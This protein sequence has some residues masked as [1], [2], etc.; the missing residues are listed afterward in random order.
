VAHFGAVMFHVLGMALQKEGNLLQKL[1]EQTVAAR[2]QVCDKLMYDHFFFFKIMIKIILIKKLLQGC[3][4]G[5]A[6]GG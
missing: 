6:A 2:A 5:N 3:C 1:L 4:A